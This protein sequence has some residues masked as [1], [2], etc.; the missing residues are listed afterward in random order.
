M[1][2]EEARVLSERNI[3]PA[4]GPRFF[5]EGGEVLFQFVIDTTNI[6][7]PR[8]ATRRDQQEHAGAWKAF[9]DAE[10]VSALDRDASGSDGGS[11]PEESPA[12]DPV[13]EPTPDLK[14]RRG[15]RKG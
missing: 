7:G 13:Q 6:L 3:M 12:V 4:R 1:R 14:P 9:C 11:L 2:P 15:K 8:P 5:R 10:G